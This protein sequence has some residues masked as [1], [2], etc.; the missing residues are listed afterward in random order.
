VHEDLPQPQNELALWSIAV[1]TVQKGDSLQVDLVEL[2][3][4]KWGYGKF[5]DWGAR[6]S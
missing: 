3:L 2:G 6:N 1:E 4:G 5:P